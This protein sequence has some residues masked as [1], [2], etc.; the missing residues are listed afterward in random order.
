LTPTTSSL[1]INTKG[2]SAKREI[3]VST[4]LDSASILVGAD[5]DNDGGAENEV[6]QHV[7]PTTSSVAIKTKGTGADKDRVVSVSSGTD[8]ST[9][10]VACDV[11]DD[12][13]GISEYG[14]ILTVTDEDGD[15]GSDMRCVADTDDDGV[16]ES[17]A[18]LRVTPT[19]SSVAIKTKG[20]GADKNRSISSTCDST[21]AIH[22]LAT[23]DDGDGVVD[24]QISST[25]DTAS[26]EIAI[27]EPGAQVAMGMKKGWDGTI[28]GRFTVENAST[29]MIELNSDGDG[30]FGAKVG[31]GVDVP[32]HRIDVAG[33]AYCDGTNWVN[34]SDVNSKENFAAVDGA[35]LLAKIDQL[36]ITRW[37]YK[38]DDESVTHIGPTAQDFH[39]AFGVGS[40]DKSIST[41]DPSGIA[42]AAIQELVRQL[43]ERDL[44]IEEMK[45]ELVRLRDEIRSGS[46]GH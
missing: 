13:D 36:Q 26:T 10:V 44:E 15:V 34:A 33:G 37:N 18:S 40:N 11:D 23:D 32:T 1:A 42:L 20:T 29:R 7:T 14:V 38:Q 2:T 22:L 16:P 35:E 4:G 41:V 8:D 21:S 6:S 17:D 46:V 9:G 28:K 45:A 3:K 5:L 31:I 30:Y 19:T 25:V 43:R 24:R 39:S 27:D 12:G